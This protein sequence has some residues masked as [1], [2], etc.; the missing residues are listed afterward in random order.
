[1]P[2]LPSESENFFFEV[3]SGSSSN[4]SRPASVPCSS[5]RHV[6]PASAPSSPRAKAQSSKARVNAAV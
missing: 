4:A 1:M 2:Y 5:R 3:P 6:L